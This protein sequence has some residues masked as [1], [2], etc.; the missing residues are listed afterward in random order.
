MTLVS[1]RPVTYSEIDNGEEKRLRRLRDQNVLEE[2]RPHALHDALA[3][4]PEEHG[5]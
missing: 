2:S 4:I 5:S 1:T 3:E